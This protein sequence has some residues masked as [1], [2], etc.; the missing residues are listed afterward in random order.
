M[1]D[2]GT[3]SNRDFEQHSTFDTPTLIEMYRTG[4]YLH[5]GRAATLREVLTVFNPEDR[6]GKTS[7]LTDA[8]I[9]YL[10]AFMMSL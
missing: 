9:D 10:V 5:D 7:H 4:P 3:Q 2:V 1:Y 8:E 6:H